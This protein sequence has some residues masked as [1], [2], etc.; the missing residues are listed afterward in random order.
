MLHSLD[1]ARAAE[2][3][4]RILT[5]PARVI[6]ARRTM[7]DLARMSEYELRDIGLTRPDLNDVTALPL[8]ADPS[9]LSSG[10]GPGAGGR[11]ADARTSRPGRGPGGTPKTTGPPQSGER[12]RSFLKERERFSGG[13]S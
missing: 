8:D 9:G 2:A 11:R 6:A 5:W 13:T 10:G 12:S 7:S 1:D 4:W 3:L